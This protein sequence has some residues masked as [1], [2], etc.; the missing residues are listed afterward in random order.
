MRLALASILIALGTQG[1]LGAFNSGG[2]YSRSS[3]SDDSRYLL[4]QCSG[5]T[6]CEQ[7]ARTECASGKAEMVSIQERPGWYARGSK[8]YVRCAAGPPPRVSEAPPAPQLPLGP[9]PLGADGFEFDDPVSTAA[10]LCGT[11]GR[12][13]QIKRDQGLCSRKAKDDSGRVSRTKLRF[14]KDE[15]CQISLSF[16]PKSAAVTSRAWLAEFRQLRNNLALKYGG[17]TRSELPGGSCRHD[18]LHCMR[19]YHSTYR[20]DWRW[21]TGE[22]ILLIM[23][24]P[25]GN[26]GEPSIRLFYKLTRVPGVERK[27]RPE[28]LML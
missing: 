6:D 15:L 5:H 20:Y 19:E 24:R 9:P 11:T 26:R 21:K 7:K 28:P 13:W 14:C 8:L 22:R 17:W 16:K 1:C 3:G 12:N 23:D 25:E 2:G 27:K 4:I 18:V 10:A